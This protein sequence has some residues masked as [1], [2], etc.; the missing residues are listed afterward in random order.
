MRLQALLLTVGSLL[1]A[2]SCGGDA[3]EPAM[4]TR[5]VVTASWPVT[6]L[7]E[8]LAPADVPVA[9]LLPAG[10]DPI[11]WQPPREAVARAQGAALIVLNG[12]GLEGWVEHAS[13]PRSRTVDASTPIASRLIEQEGVV[14]S[15]GPAGD[16]TH[17]S[18]DP[19]TFLDPTL[20]V[21]MA[22]ALRDGLARAF[23]EDR[24]G[25]EE[26]ATALLG[27]LEALG[28]ELEQLGAALEGQ[29]L[30]ASHPAYDYLARTY[31][32]DLTNLD[33]DPEAPL[34]EAGLAA[35]REAVGSG[36]LALLWES[37]PLPATA[38]RLQEEL[39]VPS[40]VWS[41][42]EAPDPER[43]GD[44]LTVQRENAQ[45]LRALLPR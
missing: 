25:I 27:D 36:A 43:A 22:G 14:H 39:G 31:G 35:V 41:P 24:S 45:R 40:L 7:T 30:V 29:R 8:R 11:T 4:R 20:L 16:H 23:P 6:S 44:F 12:A 3:P 21:P 26:R 17:A 19:H 1:A 37:A 38:A 9:C 2:A 32:W 34:D 18:V 15:H 10:A 42:A 33:L 5:E 13:L 28:S